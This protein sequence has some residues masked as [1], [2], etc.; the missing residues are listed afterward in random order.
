MT[1]APVIPCVIM[2]TDRLYILRRLWRPGRRIPVW[3][4]FGEPLVPPAGLDRA[5]ARAA[6]AASLAEAFRNLAIE[7]R[8]EFRLSEDD[9]PQ[10]PKR[11]RASAP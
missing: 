4:A 7:I 1:A 5:G 10:S 8:R 11:R 2:G 3:I 9:L 6:V